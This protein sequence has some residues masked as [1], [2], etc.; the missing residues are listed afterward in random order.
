M[1]PIR[2]RCLKC[3][4]ITRYEDKVCSCGA[5][6]KKHIYL[7]CEVGGKR[8][9]RT[10]GK[11]SRSEA[12]EIYSAWKIKLI[13]GDTAPPPSLKEICDAHIQRMQAEGKG[14]WKKVVL[15]FERALVFFGNIPAHTITPVMAQRFKTQLD[16][17]SLA[18]AY[19]DRHIAELKA[20]W[21]T[22]LDLPNPFKRVR[23]NRPDNRVTECLTADEEKRLLETARRGVP[24][25]PRFFYEMV[26]LAIH[27]G[28]RRQNILRLHTDEVDF[29]NNQIA[30]WQK[31]NR[32]H[33]V[34]MNET[35]RTAL[36]AIKPESGYFFTS[37]Y[38]KGP[39]TRFEG[40]WKRLKKLAD[41]DRPFRFHGLR[42]HFATTMLRETGNL[43]V[44]QKLCG[45][46]SP[47]VTERYAHVLPEDMR[48]A[49]AKL[50]R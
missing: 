50:D 20:A 14:Y 1:M 8:R 3:S 4:R 15:F 18:P 37:K 48:D 21:H 36:L 26:L 2:Q 41:L 39:Y 34:P 44:V 49:V 23:L 10:L 25:A 6:L 28:L 43:L 30:I 42:H 32:L 33:V 31:G 40:S 9:T 46:S 11:C 35:V 38:G 27:T 13:K 12:E 47:T 16:S 17:G 5:L 29:E 7:I 45:H 22:S 19:V 24:R